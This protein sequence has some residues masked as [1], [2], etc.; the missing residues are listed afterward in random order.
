MTKTVIHKEYAEGYRAGI[1]EERQRII[2]LLKKSQ[3][4]SYRGHDFPN[5]TEKDVNFG[6]Y[7]CCAHF[8]RIIEKGDE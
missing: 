3:D 8:I 5:G 4:E 2:E 6:W 1:K 7:R